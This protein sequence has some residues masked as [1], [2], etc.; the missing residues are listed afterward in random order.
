MWPNVKF[1]AEL[2]TFTEEILNRKFHAFC[3]EITQDVDKNYVTIK[4]VYIIKIVQYS[5]EKCL[6]F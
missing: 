1:P 4:I 5:Q 3:N 2:V 6:Y